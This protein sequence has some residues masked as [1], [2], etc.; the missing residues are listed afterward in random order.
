MH[1]KTVLKNGVRAVTAFMPGYASCACGIWINAGSRFEDKRNCGISHFIEH[2]VFKGTKKYSCEKIK[3]SIEGRGG[4]LNAFTSEELTCYYAKVLTKDIWRTLDILS[5]MVKDPLFKNED[6]EKERTVII[7]EIKMYRDLPQ[8]YVLEILG[9]L[10]WPKQPLGMNIAGDIESISSLKKKDISNFKEKYYTNP[11]IVV[12]VAGPIEHQDVVDYSKKIFPT[13]GKN[14][15]NCFKKADSAQKTQ[16]VKVLSKETEQTHIA[17]GY[18]AVSRN[19]PLKYV[20]GVL[21]VILGAN[22]SSRLFNKIREKHG[23]AY[24]ISSH[25]RYFNDTGAFFIHA[26]LDNKTVKKAIKLISEELDK[27]KQD[28]VSIGELKRAID[29]YV[30]QLLLGFESTSDNMLWIGESESAINRIMSREEAIRAIKSVTRK[31]LRDLARK[32]FNADKLNLSV[33]GPVKG[34]FEKEIKPILN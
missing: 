3:T 18:H 23:L 33:I 14:L 6:I 10:L 31:Y 25:V 4:S 32:L 15:K 11:N 8:S 19:S 20:Q 2:L 5:S 28:Y 17:L 13:D 26:G 9:E 1:Q 7:E 12:A 16:R 22:M 27:I 24:A 30:G 29:F 21:N 34:N